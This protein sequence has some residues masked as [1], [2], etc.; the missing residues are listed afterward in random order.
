[1]IKQQILIFL[2][3]WLVSSAGMWLCLNWFA[4]IDRVVYSSWLF[5]VAGLLFSLL[6]A[7]VKPIATIISLPLI[8]LTLGFFSI[9]VNT[10]MVSLTFWM[11]PGVTVT[12]GGALLSSLVMSIINGLVNFFV[13]TYNKK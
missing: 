3:R 12:F 7:T 2:F 1:M 9:L 5:V 10:A 8:I 13:P 4:S 11:L 6:N